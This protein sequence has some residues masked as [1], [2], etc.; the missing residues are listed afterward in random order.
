MKQAQHSRRIPSSARD[1][2]EEHPLT[3]WFALTCEA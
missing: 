1:P 2:P 3:D